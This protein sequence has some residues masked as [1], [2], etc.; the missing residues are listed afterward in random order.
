M[1]LWSVVEESM[2]PE[3]GTAQTSGCRLEAQDKPRLASQNRQTVSGA[4]VNKF[5][6][7]GRA[8]FPCV[9]VDRLA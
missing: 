4:L 3:T 6:L 9:H 5:K 8:S 7:S 1:W 2:V